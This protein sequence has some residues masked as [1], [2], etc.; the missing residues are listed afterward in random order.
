MERELVTEQQMLDILNQEIQTLSE[1]DG[2]EI[3]GNLVPLENVLSGC[4]WELEYPW[5]LRFQN[6]P[7]RECS[8]RIELVLEHPYR[9][10]SIEWTHPEGARPGSSE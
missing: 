9:Q 4:N 8:R 3:L 5:R 10:Y 1:C 2:T 7:D 6:G